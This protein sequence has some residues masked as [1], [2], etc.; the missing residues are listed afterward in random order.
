MKKKARQVTL[1]VREPSVV[2]LTVG[3]TAQLDRLVPAQRGYVAQRDGD[4]LAPGVS[5]RALAPGFY[6]FRT[7]SDANLHVVR[8]GVDATT[9]GSRTKEIPPP[10]AASVPDPERRGDEVSGELPAFTID[11]SL[12]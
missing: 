5:R 4:L 3:D 2:E 10:P 6:L 1:H 12:R 9:T 11:G 8:G 7:L